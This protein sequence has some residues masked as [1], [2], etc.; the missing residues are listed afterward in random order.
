MKN[1]DEW[2]SDLDAMYGASHPS[3]EKLVSQIVKMVYEDAITILENEYVYDDM[4]SE[5]IRDR[6]NEIL[7]D[8][9]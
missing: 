1:I 8:E 4:A 2:A 7:G 9:E 6:M 5:L 3:A